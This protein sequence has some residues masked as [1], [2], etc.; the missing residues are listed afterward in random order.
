MSPCDLTWTLRSLWLYHMLC[1][2]IRFDTKYVSASILSVSIIE[3]PLQ[4][5]DNHSVL[6]LINLKP[7]ESTHCSEPQSWQIL[8]PHPKAF[9]LRIQRATRVLG[10]RHRTAQ[11]SPMPHTS[12]TGPAAPARAGPQLLRK[13]RA[14]RD[15]R[16]LAGGHHGDAP[17]QPPPGPRP[18][19]W[20]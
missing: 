16:G 17:R 9:S 18:G 8:S 11:G 5:G 7:R 20:G 12:L 13:W 2:T 3:P 10:S 6:Q 19:V 14:L 15:W 1:S 4:S